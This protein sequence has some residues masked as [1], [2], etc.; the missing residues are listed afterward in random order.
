M[1]Y[2]LLYLFA[3]CCRPIP[4]I[5]APVLLPVN[6]KRKSTE[7]GKDRDKDK[8]KIEEKKPVGYWEY[9]NLT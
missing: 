7:T 8:D 5:E 4:I 2:S 9:M 6:R 1:N 3:I